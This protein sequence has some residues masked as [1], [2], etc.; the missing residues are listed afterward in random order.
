MGRGKLYEMMEK[1]GRLG[2]KQRQEQDE[3]RSK[4]ESRKNGENEQRRKSQV[5]VSYYHIAILSS[6]YSLSAKVV[7]KV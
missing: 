7:S 4:E 5:C 3:E 2:R 1:E 6:I